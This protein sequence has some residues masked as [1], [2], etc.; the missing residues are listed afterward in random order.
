MN[1]HHTELGLVVLC[2]LL[3]QVLHLTAS[4]CPNQDLAFMVAIAWTCLNLLLSGFFITF[5]EMA[6]KWMTYLRYTSAM[7]F[8]FEGLLQVELGGRTFDCSQTLTV[9]EE[10]LLG[11]VAGLM[12][13][14][15]AATGMYSAT[16]VSSSSS[17]SSSPSS[18]SGGGRYSGQLAQQQQQG[19]LPQLVNSWLANSTGR[20]CTVETSAILTYF[21]FGRSFGS[22]I[23]CLLAYWGV[24]HLATYLSL[25]LLARRERR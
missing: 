18:S 19:G 7:H 23:G 25:V 1:Q 9:G 5:R 14:A 6:F 15:T 13:T 10:R 20:G 2:S 17:S 3:L 24:L 22:T 12:P 16:G 4:L 8:A 11:L 21:D